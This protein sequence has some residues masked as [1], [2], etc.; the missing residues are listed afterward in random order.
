MTSEEFADKIDQI[1]QQSF[2]FMKWAS[3]E[4][5]DKIQ[6]LK[7]ELVDEFQ[8]LKEIERISELRDAFG[9]V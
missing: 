2:L 8:D 1:V 4:N 5:R 3:N 6:A 9:R 7:R